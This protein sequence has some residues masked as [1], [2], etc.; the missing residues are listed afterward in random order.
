MQELN[1]CGNG[2]STTKIEKRKQGLWSL[3]TQYRHRQI[4]EEKVKETPEHW[5]LRHSVQSGITGLA[6]VNGRSSLNIEQQINYD[7]EYA[8]NWSI[9]MDISI[10]F[11]GIYLNTG[12]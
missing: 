5:K 1:T 3:S 4:K 12:L 2:T 9:A 10:I 8:K 6:Q 7:C 11:N